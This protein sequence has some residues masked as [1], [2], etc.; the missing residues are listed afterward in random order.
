MQY[1]VCCASSL[2]KRSKGPIATLVL[3]LVSR[4]TCKGED[5]QLRR[6]ITPCR[7]FERALLEH[8]HCKFYSILKGVEKI[9]FGR[10]QAKRGKTW[11]HCTRGRISTH[12]HRELT[13]EI[14]TVRRRWPGPSVE[15]GHGFSKGTVRIIMVRSLYFIRIIVLYSILHIA[16]EPLH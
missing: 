16:I 12:L 6:A 14:L 4:S 3:P 15:A 5:S 11:R 10:H 9:C 7:F 2:G 13:Q 1:L 8:A